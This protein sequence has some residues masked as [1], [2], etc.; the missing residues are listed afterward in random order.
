M[1]AH[2][3]RVIHVFHPFIH[4]SIQLSTAMKSVLLLVLRIKHTPGH[5]GEKIKN[6]GK[7]RHSFLRL[8]IV[9]QTIRLHLLCRNIKNIKAF[10]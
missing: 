3:G 1:S 10:V 6:Y 7:Q 5:N 4:A 9:P 2:Y 8:L